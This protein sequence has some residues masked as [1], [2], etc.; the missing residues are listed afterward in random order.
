MSQIKV[1]KIGA[2]SGESFEIL[3]DDG[4]TV[5]ATLSTAGI[6]TLGAGVD[7]V[8]GTGAMMVGGITSLS[9]V[10]FVFEVNKSDAGGTSHV[11]AIENSY[12]GSNADVLALSVGYSSNPTNTNR[13]IT[14][15]GGGYGSTDLGRIRGD[16]AGGVDYYSAFTGHHP[17]VIAEDES[18]LSI[19]LIVSSTGE[20]WARL[21]ESCNTG[22]PKCALSLSAQDKT[23]FGVLSSWGKDSE[24]NYD[25]P[26]Y[27]KT[28]EISDV[29]TAIM[30]NSLGE[31]RVWVTNI[32]GEVTN[33][34]YITTSAIAGH[35]QLQDDDVLHNYTVA[36][37]TEEISWA[38]V[39]ETVE[40]DGAPYKKYL[41]TCTYHCG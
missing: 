10:D 21:E 2:L 33:G 36:K 18:G 17:S 24:G 31:G 13:F 23:V 25:Y 32:N 30:V 22:I 1:N 7:L 5:R 14:F 40:H 8:M 19:G 4:S 28:W 6:L 41:A 38:T 26:G 15:Y 39:T 37:C 9:D 16:G 34:D 20:T 12:N 3:D 11:A 29:E 35:G 27:V